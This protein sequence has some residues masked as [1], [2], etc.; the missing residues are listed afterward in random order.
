[1]LVGDRLLLFTAF[2]APFTPP[3]L[4]G[5]SVAVP[6]RRVMS[7]SIRL[8][9]AAWEARVMSEEMDMVGARLKAVLSAQSWK[10]TLWPLGADL[11]VISDA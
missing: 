6:E 11:V 10:A 1:M 4:A 5:A 7:A 3:V 8:E 2:E 9:R